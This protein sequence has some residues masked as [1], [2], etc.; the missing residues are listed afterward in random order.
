MIDKKLL[1][2]VGILASILLVSNLLFKNE[3][4]VLNTAQLNFEGSVD[5]PDHLKPPQLLFDG[6]SIIVTQRPV[7][8]NNLGLQMNFL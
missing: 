2:S 8:L 6:D 1:L 5:M 3:N 4:A 7:S